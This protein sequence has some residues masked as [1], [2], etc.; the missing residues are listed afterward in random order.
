MITPAQFD[1]KVIEAIADLH[2]KVASK[3]PAERLR[4]LAEH[5][6]QI[7]AALSS[8]T[9]VTATVTAS[10]LCAMLDAE[11]KELSRVV[12]NMMLRLRKIGAVGDMTNVN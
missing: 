4:I 3:K 12:R 5:I 2:S 9:A 8:Q 7:E 6:E 1:E 10:A 11:Q